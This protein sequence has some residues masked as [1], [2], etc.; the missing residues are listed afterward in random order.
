VRTLNSAKRGSPL[1]ISLLSVHLA[2]AVLDDYDV[3]IMGGRPEG[4][5]GGRV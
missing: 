1:A 3:A 5:A 2:Y 4:R